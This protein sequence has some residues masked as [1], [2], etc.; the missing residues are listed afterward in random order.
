MAE[1]FASPPA[2]G[3]IEKLRVAL[4]TLARFSTAS[5]RESR[6]P[7]TCQALAVLVQGAAPALALW[8]SSRL[9]NI[10]AAA[11]LHFSR[12]ITAAVP[13]IAALV[14]LH[15][16]AG[17]AKSLNWYLLGRV[18]EQ[19]RLRQERE[20][21]EAASSVDYVLLEQSE[22]YD[23][24]QRARNALSSRLTNLVLF[25]MEILQ[26]AVTLVGYL[27][28]LLAASPF[29]AM[30]VVL[31]AVPSAAL[32]MAA[33]RTTYIHDYDAAPARRRMAYYISVL[34]GQKAG[35][36]VRLFGLSDELWRR[37]REAH[38]RWR[39]EQT[40]RVW[41]EVRTASGSALAQTLAYVAAVTIL[42]WL[43]VHGRLNIG[44]YVVLAGAASTFQATL[45]KILGTVRK[46]AS[47]IPILSDLQRFMD[48]AAQKKK[49]SGTQSFP[50][51][52]R[53]GLEVRNLSFS[54][55]GSERMAVCDVSFSVQ[56]GEIIA[57]VGANG[58]GKSTLAR[59]IL[60]LYR[61]ASGVVCYDGLDVQE[62]APDSIA[63]N[64][65]AVFQDFAR[66][67]RPIREEL[68]PGAPDLQ[69]DDETLWQTI[70]SVGL[71]DRIRPLARGL[72]TFLNP[73]LGGADGGTE[74]SGGE[75]Q[76][77]A[78]SRALARDAAVLVL[79]EPTASLDPQAE[80]DLYD[81][82]VQM[83]AGRTTFIISHRMGIA[84]L[85]HRILV[86]DQGRL[87]E[88]GSFAEL[89]ALDGL[90]AQ[91]FRIQAAWYA[92]DAS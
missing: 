26:N 38:R 16:A 91:Y 4:D 27:I 86:L 6:V 34:L 30:V 60:G 17:A 66:F 88:D 41:T 51:P 32:K 50:V 33:A 31:P 74:L 10:V 39:G 62:I 54:Y 79:D 92:E 40:A 14:L 44:Q 89:M 5:W 22:T 25:V 42:A 84:R 15:F 65:A 11:P 63:R 35:Q 72:D 81:R 7:S 18:Q 82:F 68:A 80:V 45:E 53:E 12:S 8:A 43:I 36:E 19:V 46:V 20:L 21:L 78:I 49:S 24:L 85:S 48:L 64:C 3:R 71:E 23:L 13:W 67:G 57:V 9:V 87:V 83:A 70:R 61:P 77:V 75:W 52:M 47:D 29:L 59:L 73:A 37:W 55:P 90:F 28:L 58:A 2:G 1:A 56:P 69:H 76:K